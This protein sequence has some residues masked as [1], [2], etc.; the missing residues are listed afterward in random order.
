MD[1][2]RNVH[3][4]SETQEL[5]VSRTPEPRQRQGFAQSPWPA[6]VV[7]VLLGGASPVLSKYLLRTVSVESLLIWRYTLSLLVL[8]PVIRWGAGRRRMSER[9]AQARP[10]AYFSLACVAILGSGVGAVLFTSSLA[11]APAAVSNSLSKAGPLLVAFLAYLL[12]NE[13]VSLGTISLL[14]AM[15]L[16]AGLLGA[17]EASGPLTRAPIPM[18]GA[19]LAVA[20][21]LTRALAEVAAKSSLSVWP[22]VNVAAVRFL[23]GA[24]IAAVLGLARPGTLG[25]LPQT[26][27]QWLALLTLSWLCTALPIALYYRGVARLPVHIVTGVRTSGA[28]VTAVISRVTLGESL[29]ILHWLG[30]GSLLLAAY[31]MASLPTQPARPR[32]KRRGP[33]RSLLHFVTMVVAGSVLLTGLLQAWQL[34]ALMQRQ[35]QATL[36]RAAALVGEVVGL[37]DALP[38]S[39]LRSFTQRAVE[40]HISTPGYT[41]EFVYIVV[42]DASGNPVAW[43]F[44]RGYGWDGTPE[45][46]KAL[47]LVRGGPEALGRHDLLPAHVTVY[48]DGTH[49]G[50]LYIGYRASIAWWPLLAVLART[51]ALAAVLAL[52]AAAGVSRAV[53]GALGSLAAVVTEVHERAV[54]AAEDSRSSP[55]V[56]QGQLFASLE[57]WLREEHVVLPYDRRPRVVALARAPGD[58]QEWLGV[59]LAALAESDGSLAGTAKG[60]LVAQWGG[61]V[62]EVDDPTRAYLWA[63]ALPGDKLLAAVDGDWESLADVID[64]ATAWLEEQG[65]HPGGMILAT[66]DFAGLAAERLTL[67]QADEG[68]YRVE[69]NAS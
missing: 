58:I 44:R 68:L 69:D 26:P 23:G 65:P 13:A 36:G 9:P 37:G 18:L 24:V 25:L 53:R 54:V 30:I 59:A 28:V 35:V 8:L 46:E 11:Y 12:L 31:A 1:P 29:N 19:V 15:L 32:A 20:A 17:G 48:G 56:T 3:S 67:E 42:T 34:Q 41:A 33:V 14:V 43:A 49:V 10:F 4:V 64:R 60:W 2:G 45:H 16:A 51:G 55:S 66:Q 57:D 38:R 47:R 6:V 52:A 5:T 40:E 39:A 27:E 22:A 50:D 21:G 62:L 61:D 63:A 7:A